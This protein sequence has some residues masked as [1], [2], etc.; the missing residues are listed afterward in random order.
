M[1]PPSISFD[2]DRCY[3]AAHTIYTHSLYWQVFV[4]E[5]SL[6]AGKMKHY[7]IYCT[8]TFRSYKATMSPVLLIQD[9]WRHIE[10]NDQISIF[11]F[12]NAASSSPLT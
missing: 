12:M 5:L 4:L 1:R 11:T 3:S 2:K 9:D 6:E 10:A 7:F 8:A